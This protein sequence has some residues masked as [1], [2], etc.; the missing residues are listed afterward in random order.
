M[1]KRLL[2]FMASLLLCGAAS[3]QNLP[4][5]VR[6]HD[7][8][9]PVVAQVVLDETPVTSGWM[10]NA[11]VGDDLR[12]T[13]EIQTDLQNTYWIQVYYDTPAQHAWQPTGE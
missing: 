9:M 3:A 8:N 11:Y 7:N 12:G 13:A 2:C 6:A 4:A 10:L 5:Y 1:N